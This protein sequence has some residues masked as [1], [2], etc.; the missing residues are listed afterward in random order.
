MTNR[1]REKRVNL[2]PKA[3]HSKAQG[4]RYSGAPWVTVPTKNPVTSTGFHNIVQPRWSRL[5]SRTG[6][7]GCAAR[8]WAS[9]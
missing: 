5:I 4:R 2:M 9:E 7:P 3:F 6:Y 8:P 1:K